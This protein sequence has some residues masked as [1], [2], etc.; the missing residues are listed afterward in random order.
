MAKKVILG[1]ES[2]KEKK[3]FRFKIKIQL[4]KQIFPIEN[5]YEYVI[6][7]DIPTTFRFGCLIMAQTLKNEV[8][9]LAKLK[10]KFFSV[11]CTHYHRYNPINDQGSVKAVV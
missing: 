9:A 11:F 5:Q 3:K 7:L 10:R 8:K 6:S 4:G 1:G 2:L